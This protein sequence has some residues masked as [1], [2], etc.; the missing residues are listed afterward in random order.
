MSTEIAQVK[1]YYDREANTLTVWLGEPTEAYVAE[2]TG[3]VEFRFPSD[4]RCA[5]RI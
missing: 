4:R 2:E 5:G 3:E 1:A